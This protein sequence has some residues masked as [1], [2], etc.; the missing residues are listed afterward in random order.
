M[1]NTMEYKGYVGSVEFSEA[2]GLFFGK[3]MGIRALVSYEGTNVGVKADSASLQAMFATQK[4]KEGSLGDEKK[5]FLKYFVVF[6]KLNLGADVS[7]SN[8][9]YLDI[10]SYVKYVNWQKNNE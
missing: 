5:K 7:Q 8:A 10:S 3:V 2:D 4:S 9:D 6:S 1:K